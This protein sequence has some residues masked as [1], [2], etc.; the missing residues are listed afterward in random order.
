MAANYFL[1]NG[2]DGYSNSVCLLSNGYLTT[3]FNDISTL[4]LATMSISKERSQ[5]IL[6]EYNPNLDLSGFFYIATSP[7]S[8]N[9]VKT[10][11]AIFDYENPKTTK[12]FN[13]LKYFAKQREYKVNNGLSIQLDF[14]TE[15]NDYIRT[16]LFDILDRPKSDVLN[17]MDD[18][19]Q[20]A[21]R[22]KKILNN[23]YKDNTIP[24]NKYINSNIYVLKEIL[25]GYTALRNLALEYIRLKS[26]DDLVLKNILLE[27][28]KWENRGM[29]YTKPV[30]YEKENIPKREVYKQ[31]K[32]ED[33]MYIPKVR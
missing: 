17:V 33:F 31:L 9:E 7:N 11:A 29:E 3:N 28:K 2:K 14:D 10:Y 30:K 15:L 22:L 1:M 19:S 23:R 12:V 24:T 8:K 27:R 20:V 26:K 5:E 6:K 13:G 4:D 25:S 21:S 32:L 18:Y 16:I